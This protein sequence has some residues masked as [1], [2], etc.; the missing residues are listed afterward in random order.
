MAHSQ[1]RLLFGCWNLFY[2][3]SESTSMTKESRSAQIGEDRKRKRTFL[4]RAKTLYLKA[5]YLC[6]N[7]YLSVAII[8]PGTPLRPFCTTDIESFSHSFL[9]THEVVKVTTQQDVETVCYSLF[10]DGPLTLLC[11]MHNCLN[12]ST[13]RNQS[14]QRWSLL[15]KV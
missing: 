3:C 15:M 9:N 14:V 8:M 2:V 1:S 13:G 6:Y 10:N 4:Y 5:C 7:C 11:V 12:Y